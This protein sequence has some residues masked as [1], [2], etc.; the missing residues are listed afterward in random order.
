MKSFRFFTG[1]RFLALACWIGL[2]LGGAALTP[3]AVAAPDAASGLSLAKLVVALKPDKNPELM[4]QEKR[5]LEGFLTREVGRPVEVVIPLSAA[6][7]LEGLANGS[8]DLGYL[9]AT[10]MVNARNRSIARVLLAGE[11]ADGRTAYDSYWVVKKDS[12]HRSIADLRGRPVAFA[13]KTSTSGFVIPLLDLRSRGLI[14][15]DGNA[16]AFFGR[17]NLYFGVGYVSAIE[18]VLA[19]DAEAAAVSY[20]VLDRDKHLSADQR[21]QLRVLQKQG[22]VPSHVI[23]VRASL[24]D[25]DIALLRSAVLGLN[26][27][28]QSVLRDKLFTTRLVPVDEAAHL[29]PLADGLALA[30]R[31]LR[32]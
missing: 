1:R 23:A 7:I 2:A 10:D 19:G 14:G 16:E 27:P 6:T 8:I 21:S 5:A 28:E 15:E 20:Y 4:L 24:G 25:A 9:S 17:G 26:T 22:P 12:P 31:A 3:V 11:F 13:S 32:Q 18:R 30:G 29:A